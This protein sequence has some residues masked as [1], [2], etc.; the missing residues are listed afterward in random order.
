VL[1]PAQVA[2]YGTLRGYAGAAEQAGNKGG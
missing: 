2:T 1:T